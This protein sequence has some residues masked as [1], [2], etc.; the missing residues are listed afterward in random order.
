MGNIFN[1]PLS[2]IMQTDIARHCASLHVDQFE[3]C[4]DC[5]HKYLCGGGCRAHSYYE[6]KNLSSYD[7]YCPMTKMFYDNITDKMHEKY[8]SKG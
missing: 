8:A 1:E 3:V 4:G 6:Y 5:E 7:F 2:N